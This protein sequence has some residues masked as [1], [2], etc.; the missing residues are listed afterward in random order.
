MVHPSCLTDPSVLVVADASV[1]INLNATGRSADILDALPNRMA[2]VEEVSF[3]MRNGRRN[4]INDADELSALVSA[5]HVEI[6]QLGDLGM[7]HFEDLVVGSTAKTLDDGEA[8]TIAY[9]IQQNAIA[10]I[11]ERKANRICVERFPELETGCTVDLFAHPLA[12]ETLGPK[13]L[14]DAVYNALYHGRMRVLPHHVNWVIDLIG[15][16][17]AANCLSIPNSLRCVG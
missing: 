2:I 14:A 11:D 16:D 15:Q 4:R 5:N 3:E 17:R 10:L 8:A 6:V 13:G 9:A 7:Q 1:V 12:H